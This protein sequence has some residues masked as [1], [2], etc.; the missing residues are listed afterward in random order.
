M[1][2]AG[3]L[4]AS[5]AQGTMLACTSCT[6]WRARVCENRVVPSGL[7][8]SPAKTPELNQG[9]G[10]PWWAAELVGGKGPQSLQWDTGTPGYLDNCGPAAAFL[11]AQLSTR[12]SCLHLTVQLMGGLVL[13]PGLQVS[14]HLFCACG[15]PLGLTTCALC[16]RCWGVREEHHR[17]ADEVSAVHQR[18]R[19]NS[20]LPSS[21]AVPV[22]SP[23]GPASL[24]RAQNLLRGSH[25]SSGPSGII[26]EDGYS[27]EECRQ[28][29]AVVYSNTIQSIMA[30]VKAMGNLQIDFADPSRASGGT[31]LQL[32]DLHRCAQDDARQLFALSCTAEEQGVLPDDLSGVIR[33]LWADHGVQA[34]FGRSREYQLNDSAA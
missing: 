13:P 5:S 29:R 19:P 32:P 24:S 27:E 33:R 34:C 6:G 26:H 23:T 9:S 12:P 11:V 31:L 30:I 8:K 17:Q 2:Y 14:G 21:S 7:A 18:Q 10:E 15:A 16:S 4:P 1:E 3:H 28:Y 22:L 20:N 25:L